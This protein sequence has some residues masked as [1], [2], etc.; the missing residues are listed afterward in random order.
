[1]I[2]N[3]IPPAT[4]PPMIA[5]VFCDEDEEVWLTALDLGV[6][7]GGGV[8]DDDP[9][10]PDDPP[11][12]FCVAADVFD[13]GGGGV[14][15]GV[16]EGAWVKRGAVT[17]VVALLFWQMYRCGV[18]HDVVIHSPGDES[19]LIVI[20]SNPGPVGFVYFQF[21]YRNSLSVCHF[22]VHLVSPM[23]YC[24]DIFDGLLSISES[25]A[26]SDAVK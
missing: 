23:K 15:R 6:W 8:K 11:A 5:A 13:R 19:L 1:M 4:T 16:V 3:P 18:S 25:I 9:P 21:V 2:N 10:D 22:H 17:L 20:Q 24:T 14:L 26:V 7:P 12:G